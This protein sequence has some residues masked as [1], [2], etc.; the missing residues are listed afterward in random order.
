[1]LAMAGVVSDRLGKGGV[2]KLGII[3]ANK[4]YNRNWL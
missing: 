2:T 1:M 3:R 4:F